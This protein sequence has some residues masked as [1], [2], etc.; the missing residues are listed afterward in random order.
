[1]IRYAVVSL[2]AGTGLAAFTSDA[3]AQDS[4]V[5]EYAVKFVCGTPD[6]PA[7]APGR[8]FTAINVHNPNPDTV[9]VR[10]KYAFTLAGEQRAPIVWDRRPLSVMPDQALEIDCTGITRVRRAPFLKGFAVLLSPLPL[11]IVAVYTAAG[12][13]GRRGGGAGA[14]GAVG[15]RARPGRPPRP[16]PG[17]LPRPGG[18]FDPQ[19]GLGRGEQPLGHRGDHPKHRDRRRAG[20]DRARDRSVHARPH[21]RAAERHR[22]DSAAG[23]GS[24]RYRHVLPAL[25]GVQP[26]REPGRDGGLQ[27]RAGGMP[28]GQQYPAIRGPRVMLQLR[29]QATLH[30]PGAAAAYLRPAEPR[31]FL[32]EAVA[33]AR[34]TRRPKGEPK[35]TGPV[36]LR[37]ADPRENRDP[38]REP[39]QRRHTLALEQAGELEAVVEAQQPGHE[40]RRADRALAEQHRLGDGTRQQR[41]LRSDD[42]NPF[43]RLCQPV[44]PQTA[45]HANSVERRSE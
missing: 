6:R 44:R 28:G 21:R 9:Q 11:D 2:V 39:V 16:P 27:E 37:R 13:T 10:R 4:L 25:L 7:A 40:A 36:V 18:G 32:H 38:R 1:M 20:D 41:H 42:A 14:W 23:S 43:Q 5:N 12:G 29:Q 33:G 24:H 26:R 45:L 22:A 17:R 34:M 8:Y 19:A 35:Q 15:L 3:R 30:P 31:D